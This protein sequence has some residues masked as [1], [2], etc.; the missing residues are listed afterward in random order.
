M[1]HFLD[2]SVLRRSEAPG[3]ILKLPKHHPNG[4]ARRKLPSNC[5]PHREFRIIVDASKCNGGLF[6]LF[7]ATRVQGIRKKIR[8]FSNLLASKVAEI[9]HGLLRSRRYRRYVWPLGNLHLKK[10]S[11]YEQHLL[12]RT[13][14]LDVLQILQESLYQR[15]KTT[16]FGYVFLF[17]SYFHLLVVLSL[18]LCGADGEGHKCAA[19]LSTGRSALLLFLSRQA[20]TIVAVG[21]G[22][23]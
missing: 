9:G 22:A 7:F 11:C 14:Y 8:V 17:F 4:L 21:D 2:G 15:D 13:G 20:S 10:S 18:H 6:F 16:L 23:R 1:K 3:R 19:G 12:K 5:A